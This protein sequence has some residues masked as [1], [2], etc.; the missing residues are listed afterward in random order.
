MGRKDVTMRED[1]DGKLRFS[2]SK[3]CENAI[4]I[5][6]H[7]SFVVIATKKPDR[8][9][10]N[11]YHVSLFLREKSVG[12]ITRIESETDIEFETEVTW[13]NSRILK[14]VSGL[15]SNGT[16][17]GYLEEYEYMLQCFNKGNEFFEEQDS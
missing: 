11:L 12:V 17:N 2:Y 5:D 8:R 14:Y 6:L 10:D 4:I 15:M 13:I 7:N 9:R 16:M 3:Y 1:R